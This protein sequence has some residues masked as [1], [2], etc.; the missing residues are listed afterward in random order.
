MIHGVCTFGVQI[1]QALYA[2]LMYSH[3]RYLM[4]LCSNHIRLTLRL[5]VLLISQ[6]L[7]LFSCIHICSALCKSVA[8]ILEVLYVI[9]AFVVM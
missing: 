6:V 1:S 3:Q 7:M 8:L 9:K 5:S 4:L 2:C